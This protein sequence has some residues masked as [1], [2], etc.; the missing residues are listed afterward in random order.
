MRVSGITLS[1]Y[2]AFKDR[3]VLTI[4]PLTVII[5]KNGSGKSLLSR[6]PLLLATAV[7]RDPG[8][9]LDLAAGG[10]DHA[11]SFQDIVNMRSA[12]TFSLGAKISEGEK[13]YDF[14]TTLRYVNETRSL[15]IEGFSLSVDG[16]VQMRAEIAAAEHLASLLPVYNI[17]GPAY[18][19]A[20]VPLVFDGLFPV[21]ELGDYAELV[22]TAR[23]AFRLALPM[24]SYLGPFRAEP[25][26]AM[27]QPSQMIRDL[28]PRGERALEFLAD[29]RLRHGGQVSTAVSDWFAKSL[30]HGVSVDVSGEQPKIT[31]SDRASGLE[32]NLSDTGAGFS[33]SIPVT[34]QNIAFQQGRLSASMLIVEQPELH[35]HPA[36]HGDLADLILTSASSHGATCIVET[37]SEQFIMR[38]R[39]RVAEGLDPNAIAIWS[40]DHKDGEG[41]EPEALRVIHLDQNGDPESW[42]TGVF[43]EAFDD[44]TLMRKASRGRSE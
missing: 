27:R 44:L 31:I 17:T 43:E 28:G 20:E 8:G 29:D 23:E 24:P 1:R 26:R 3:H 2:R 21:D 5:G 34:V 35:L 37:H 11:A 9:P 30:G 42:P 16:V 15:G 7:S 36:A 18:T 39:R 13:S 33:Q 14:E 40:L 25:E 6:L 10:V 19:M 22:N 38:L 12:L 4:A 32:V 41:Q